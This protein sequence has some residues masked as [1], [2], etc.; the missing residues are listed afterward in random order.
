MTHFLEN[1]IAE[2]YQECFGGKLCV[3][4]VFHVFYYL[5]ASKKKK[6]KKSQRKIIFGQ[7]KKYDLLLGIVFH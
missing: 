1:I 5:I 2:T 4:I 7:Y 6:K 3:R